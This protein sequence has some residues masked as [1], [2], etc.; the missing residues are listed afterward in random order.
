MNALI[1]ETAFLGDAI[2]SLSL[3][4]AIKESNPRSRVT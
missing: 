1:I 2:V 4:R 3:A